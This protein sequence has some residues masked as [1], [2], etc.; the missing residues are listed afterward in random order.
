VKFN[1]WREVLQ[2]KCFAYVGQNRV[3][4]AQVQWDEVQMRFGVRI[5]DR[6]V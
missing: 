4:G 5:R 6:E 2:S 1:L 3:Y